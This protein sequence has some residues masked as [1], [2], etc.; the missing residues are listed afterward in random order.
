M[1]S[2]I[3]GATANQSFLYTFAGQQLS[4]TLTTTRG[5]T[6]QTLA[7]GGSPPARLNFKRGDAHVLGTPANG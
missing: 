2:P 3:R 1:R 6:R 4:A 5:N 7:A